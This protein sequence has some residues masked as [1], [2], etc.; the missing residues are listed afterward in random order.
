MS[1]FTIIIVS[2]MKENSCNFKKINQSVH[3]N[4]ILISLLLLIVI[5]NIIIV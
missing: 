1:R 3:V 4:M 2:S 5:I